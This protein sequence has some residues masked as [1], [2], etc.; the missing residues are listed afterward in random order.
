[1]ENMTEQT[2]TTQK[3]TLDKD[4]VVSLIAE[5]ES[6]AKKDVKT[7]LDS[8]IQIFEESALSETEISVRGFGKLTFSVLPARKGYNKQTGE[9]I[10]LPPVKRILF[11]LAENI[12]FPLPPE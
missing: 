4:A 9:M 8:L 11:R 6:F 10:D 2:Q 7:I 12:R 1:M 3:T 5:R